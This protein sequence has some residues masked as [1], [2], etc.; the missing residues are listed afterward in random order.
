M[1]DHNSLLTKYIDSDLIEYIVERN[2]QPGDRV[3]SLTEL[4]AELS[5][6]ISKLREQLEVARALGLVEVRPRTGIRCIGFDFMPALRMSLFFA[7]A[8]QQSNFEMYSN[9][10]V[11]I[12]TAYWDEATTLLTYEDKQ[13]LKTLIGKA[14]AKLRSEH[15]IIP[16]AEHRAFHMGIFKRLDN[17]F[18]KGLLDTYWEAY[19]AVELNRYA[20]YTYHERV[21]TYHER[22]ADQ[23]WEGDY[24]GSLET[25]IE[26]TRLL[27][28]QPTRD[29]KEKQRI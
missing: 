29:G 4:S 10:R 27:R 6:S 11:H 26:H 15:I 23:I 20:D 8:T 19:E 1:I 3:P 7:L 21:W 17:P 12:E 16:H 14:W 2:L 28:Y 25:F 9:L 22:I 5:I 13:A 18:V 24:Q